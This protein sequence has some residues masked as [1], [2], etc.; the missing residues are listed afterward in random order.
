LVLL[1]AS[2][3]VALQAV[4]TT[5]MALAA[6]ELASEDGV[7]CT[8]LSSIQ[9]LA[10]MTT[11]C[12]DKTGTLTLNELHMNEPWINVEA[13]ATKEALFLLAALAS[14]FTSPHR[15]AIDECIMGSVG[16]EE[17]SEW[18]QLHFTPFEPALKVEYVFV[19]WVNDV[20]V[21][22]LCLEMRGSCETL[23]CGLL[24]SYNQGLSA[25]IATSWAH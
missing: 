24:C 12:L 2:L 7:I 10:C 20:F 13:G 11:L 23:C 4:S 22:K 9:D 8:K 25:N 1:I 5:T 18:K 15:D 17:L 3:P 14:D 19:V 6:R 21:P 16:V